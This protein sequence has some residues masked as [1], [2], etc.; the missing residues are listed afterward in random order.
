MASTLPLIPASGTTLLLVDVGYDGLHVFL[1]ISVC[2]E[3]H[4]II[5]ND[6]CYTIGQDI[7]ER[8]DICI[9]HKSMRPVYIIFKIVSM[10]LSLMEVNGDQEMIESA[11]RLV[12]LLFIYSGILS[13]HYCNCSMCIL[14][15]L[16]KSTQ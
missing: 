5:K 4:K 14:S 2:L 16:T 15:L 6:I 1:G 10:G 11:Y 9:F 3:I 8:E 12:L 7:L 13:I